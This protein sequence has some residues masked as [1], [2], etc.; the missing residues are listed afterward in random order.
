MALVDP[1]NPGELLSCALDEIL[2]CTS[3]R[4]GGI[5]V[6]ASAVGRPIGKFAK[7]TIGSS[8]WGR[9]LF[10]SCMFGTGNMTE[11]GQITNASTTP[12]PQV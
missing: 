11:G 3:D 10:L 12:E 2:V 6:D 7:E 8:V 5:L 9:I 4:G 1:S